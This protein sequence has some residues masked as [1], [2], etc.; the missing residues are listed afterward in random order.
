M[1]KQYFRNKYF[2]K[3]C[4]V[5]FYEL[6]LGFIISGKKVN[7]KQIKQFSLKPEPKEECQKIRANI[8]LPVRK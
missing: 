2:K 4:R 3:N 1:E 8:R 5:R 6:K 7:S